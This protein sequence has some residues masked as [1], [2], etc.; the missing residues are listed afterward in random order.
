MGVPLWLPP[1]M[2][3]EVQT[4]DFANF[5]PFFIPFGEVSFQTVIG[6][7]IFLLNMQIPT[8]LSLHVRSNVCKKLQGEKHGRNVLKTQC[9]LDAHKAGYAEE[10]GQL[11]L[12]LLYW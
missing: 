12:C 11:A 6:F 4:S 10:L 7:Q 1:A 3:L 8:T 9:H 5:S 2:A